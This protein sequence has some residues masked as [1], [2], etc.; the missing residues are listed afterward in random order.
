MSSIVIHTEIRTSP[1]SVDELL[2]LV[3]DPAAGGTALFLGTVRD[4]TP[5]APGA[6]VTGLEYEAHPRAA[7]LLREVAEKVAT[8]HDLVALAAVHRVGPLAVG[9]TAVV[10]VASAA[11][12][13][14][15]FDA[16]RALIDTLK[17]Q[18]P[19]WK[20]EGFQDG[21]HTWVGI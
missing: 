14:Q 7:E 19:I 17:E 21:S 3:A 20:R 5:E 13:G 11:H 1:L 18:V 8:D 15:A 6:V 4:H 9:D 10:V 2:A 16:C 12:R